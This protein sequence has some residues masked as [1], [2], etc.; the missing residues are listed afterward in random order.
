MD[1]FALRKG[2]TYGT[3]LIDLERR[4]PVALLPDRTADTLAQWLQASPGVQVIT[5]DRATAYADGARHGAPTAT[6]IADRFHLLRNLAEALEQV[7]HQHRSVL[8]TL[9]CRPPG[10]PWRSRP[11]P[12][13]SRHRRLLR[14]P[15]L[16]PSCYHPQGRPRA[17]PTGASAMSRSANW[18]AKVGRSRRLPSRSGCIGKPSPS[19]SGPT[20]TRSGHAHPVCSIRISSIC[21]TVGIGGVGRACGSMRTCN[22]RAIGVGGQL[23][24][25]TSHSSV[26]P[27]NLA[28]TS[29]PS[30]GT[31]DDRL[32][33]GP[34]RG[35]DKSYAP[36]HAVLYYIL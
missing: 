26:R 27:T 15:R 11:R 9:Q 25:A 13:S 5:R 2:Q 7:F 24:S 1:D 10:A 33:P 22:G 6:Q 28:K 4:Q 32:C 29:L 3:V 34:R 35:F 19:M 31:E 12:P 21:S 36:R 8:Q 20:A 17:T 18:H 14:R 30:V 16:P 23:C